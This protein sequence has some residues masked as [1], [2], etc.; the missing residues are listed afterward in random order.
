MKLNDP[1]IL[2]VFSRRRITKV[3][4]ST[5]LLSFLLVHAGP[6]GGV[7]YCDGAT[8]RIDNTADYTI[9]WRQ[10]LSHIQRGIT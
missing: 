9:L 1:K 8:M 2:F 10:S 7:N 3:E 6:R 4:Y 5:Y